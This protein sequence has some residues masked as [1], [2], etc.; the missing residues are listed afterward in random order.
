MKKL[1]VTLTIILAGFPPCGVSTTTL[2]AS[3]IPIPA[4]ASMPL[5]DIHVEI[6]PSAGGLAAVVTGEFTFAYIPE[7]VNSMMLPVPPDVNNI[8]LSADDV[9]LPWSWSGETPHSGAVP[10][11][12]LPLSGTRIVQ[13]TVASPGTSSCVRKSPRTVVGW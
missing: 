12:P 13:D 6:K 7:D 9:E 2:V 11:V 1:V 8:R 4:P 3:P 10:A 5:E